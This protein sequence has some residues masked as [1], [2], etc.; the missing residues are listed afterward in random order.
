MSVE[1]QKPQCSTHK[2][3]AEDSKFTDVGQIDDIEVSGHD[4]VAAD[5][6][7][8]RQ[9]TTVDRRHTGGDTVD[10]VGQVAGIA[11]GRNHKYHHDDEQHPSILHRPR[12]H[13]A[14]QPRVVE[15]IVLH[16]RDGSLQ[17]IGD[18]RMEGDSQTHR[19]SQQHL[20]EH[21][22]LT[23]KACLSAGLLQVVIQEAHHTHPHR[24]AEHN[25]HIDIVK[26]GEK[27]CRHNDSHQDKQATHGGGFR[28]LSCTFKTK[29]GA[30]LVHHAQLVLHP[31]D[32]WTSQKQHDEKRR[33]HASSRSKR[34]VL[35][36][37]RSG[38]VYRFV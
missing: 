10:A 24:G 12:A 11:Y 23:R 35:K 16:K 34:D 31:A 26:L 32:E 38:E 7:Q 25:L 8:Q 18:V 5:P 17:R 2:G 20:P 36:H 15:F 29:F 1:P 30:H 3:G 22:V 21:L 27:E 14:D 28:F 13:P 19:E 33:D 4:D 37:P 9:C 6:C